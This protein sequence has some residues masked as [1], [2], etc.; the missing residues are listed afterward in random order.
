MLD[1][2]KW[3]IA[4]GVALGLVFG[5]YKLYQTGWDAAMAKQVSDQ[6]IAIKAAVEQAKIEWQSTNQITSNGIAN[7]N[8][9][10]QKLEVIVR[11]APTIKAPM[12]TDV[13]SDFGRVYNAAINT[14]KA[15]AGTGGKL[16]AT[17]VPDK[18]SGDAAH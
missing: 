3:I 7:V 6:N 10:K 16:P 15:G 12:C 1:E 5:G 13:G 9:T 14:I 11:Q 17:E 2:V 8:D 4:A 18:P